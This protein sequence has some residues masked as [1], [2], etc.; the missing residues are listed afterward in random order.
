MLAPWVVALRMAS[1]AGGAG[2]RQAALDADQ[3]LASADGAAVAAAAAA[4]TEASA[5]DA[6]AQ[7]L[8]AQVDA[9]ACMAEQQ[10]ESDSLR[11]QL[12]LKLFDLGVVAAHT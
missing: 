12:E 5:L 10:S 1:A 3:A 8:G 7:L 2:V 11:L 6:I 9:R 4:L